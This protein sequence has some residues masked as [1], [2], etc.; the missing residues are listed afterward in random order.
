M[1]E[2]RA[3]LGDDVASWE[4]DGV[5]VHVTF[6]VERGPGTAVVGA[7]SRPVVARTWVPDS[8]NPRPSTTA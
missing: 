6:T 1:V 7:G 5:P 4:Q 3:T 8:G 2:I